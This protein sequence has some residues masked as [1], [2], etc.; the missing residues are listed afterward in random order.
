MT[1]LHFPKTLRAAAVALALGGTA[2]T[3]M[4]V[5]AQDVDLNFRFGGPGFEFRF[6]DGRRH[7]MTNREVRRELR[8]RGYDDIRFRDRRGRVVVVFAERGRRDYRITFDTCRG[9]ILDR[10]RLRR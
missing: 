9:R 7:C 3:G 2:F 8:A 6:G 10:D 5:Q 4:P 1:S